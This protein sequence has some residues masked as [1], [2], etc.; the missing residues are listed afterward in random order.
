MKM[1][2]RERLERC[3]QMQALDVPRVIRKCEQIQLLK[4]RRHVPKA[5]ELKLLDKYT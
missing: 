2:K 5:E 3:V 1:G 4:L